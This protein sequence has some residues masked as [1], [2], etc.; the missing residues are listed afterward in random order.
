MSIVVAGEAEA[1]LFVYSLLK[2]L[3]MPISP[4]EEAAEAAIWEG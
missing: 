4:L 2:P 1:I 3:G